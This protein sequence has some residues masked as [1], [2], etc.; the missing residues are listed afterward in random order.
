MSNIKLITVTSHPEH[1]TTLIQSA[2]LHGWDLS[3][4]QVEWKGYGTKLVATYEYLK[5]HPELNRFV[6]CDAFDVVVMGGPEEF[7]K[8]CTAGQTFVCSAEK[9]C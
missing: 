4:I 7:E 2:K 8:K 5:Q 9:G 1:A 6:F 3:V